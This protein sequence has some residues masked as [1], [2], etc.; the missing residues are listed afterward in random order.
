MSAI[1]FIKQLVRK[2]RALFRKDA[3]HGISFFFLHS[4]HFKYHHGFRLFR[5]KSSHIQCSAYSITTVM[6]FGA[7]LG[8]KLI[9]ILL[10]WIFFATVMRTLH[11]PSTS[12]K[13]ILNAFLK[14]WQNELS[15]GTFHQFN[16]FSRSLSWS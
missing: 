5:L 6:S 2:R 10:K 7:S 9:I 15:S 3:F 1:N 8:F 13:A 4:A 16:N 14:L 12:L 11:S